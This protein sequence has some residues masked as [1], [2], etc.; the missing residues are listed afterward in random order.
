MFALSTLYFAP[1]PM[2]IT[3]YVSAGRYLQTIASILYIIYPLGPAL[4]YPSDR[5]ELKR[6]RSVI[7]K[8]RSVSQYTM[9]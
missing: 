2:T 7:I 4:G 5:G 9:R 3:V 1:F 8:D 6:R